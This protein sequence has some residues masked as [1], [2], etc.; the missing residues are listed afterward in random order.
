MY[1]DSNIEDQNSKQDQFNIL[2]TNYEGP[3]D[4]LLDL[5]KKQ[6]VDLSEISVLEL[7]QQYINFIGNLSQIHLEVAA[8]YLVMAAWLT[9]LKSRLLLPK[10]EKQEEYTPEELEEALR[11]QLQ[12]LEA[13]QKTSKILH[14]RPLIDRDIFYG[15][16][17]GG[18]NTKFIITYTSSLYDLL[19]SYASI[20][21]KHDI[22][23]SLTIN[24]SELYSVDQ[25]IQRLKNIF[26]SIKEWTNLFNIMPKLG[27]NNLVN[28]SIVT[29]NFVASLELSKNGVIDLKQEGTFGNIYLKIK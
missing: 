9:Y 29:A 17:K 3:I 22:A 6:K 21:T 12:R 10:D 13:I 11:Y 16:Y 20:I 25:A 4:L 2:L 15:N 19:K 8:D 26:G 14:Q 5:A 24:T 7:A 18:K 27:M 28:K 23:H 1:Q